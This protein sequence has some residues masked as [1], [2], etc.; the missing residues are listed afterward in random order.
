MPPIPD[1]RHNVEAD[2]PKRERGA[3]SPPPRTGEDV[4]ARPREYR[5]SDDIATDVRAAQRLGVGDRYG[6][7]S[8]TC[9]YGGLKPGLFCVSAQSTG[10]GIAAR[11]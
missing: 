2:P 8:I 10:Y 1:L 11:G 9:P 6:V 7:R 5:P 4:G 3:C